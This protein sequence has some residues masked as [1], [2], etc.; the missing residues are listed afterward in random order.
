LPINR[1]II[2]PLYQKHKLRSSEITLKCKLVT[3]LFACKTVSSSPPFTGPEQQPNHTV[4][5]QIHQRVVDALA[6]GVGRGLEMRAGNVDAKT[7][8]IEQASHLVPQTRYQSDFTRSQDIGRGIV[9]VLD[10]VNAV[11]PH[12][13]IA[14]AVALGRVAVFHRQDDRQI[15]VVGEGNIIILAVGNLSLR[16]H[17]ALAVG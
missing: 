5:R 17:A 3:A 2:P 7:R 12:R 10:Q 8:Q 9:G 15:G 6:L 11:H 1:H 16:A 4:N 14:E 13:D